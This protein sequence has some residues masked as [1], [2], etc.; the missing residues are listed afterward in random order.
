M[1]QLR[2][3]IFQ[4]APGVW[5]ARGLEHDIVAEAWSIGESVRA[6]VRMLDAHTAFDIRHQHEP[7]SAFGP[8]P[9]RCW[10]FYKTGT[11][12]PL[13]QLGIDLPHDWDIRVVV[14]HGNPS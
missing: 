11:P 14:S 4:E 3:L 12:V 13:A 9:Q 7:L 2:L 10:N 6:V 1:A 8:A 5:M